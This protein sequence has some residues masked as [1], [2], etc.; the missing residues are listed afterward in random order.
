VSSER[1]P[2]QRPG[3]FGYGS[4]DQSVEI[5]SPGVLE[6]GL[7]GAERK[8][9]SFNSRKTLRNLARNSRDIHKKKSARWSIQSLMV[10][11]DL[12]RKTEGLSLILDQSSGTVKDVLGPGQCLE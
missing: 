6:S 7:E 8:G 5:P 2:S 1:D 10:V 4:R 3:V 12:K 11:R 9:T